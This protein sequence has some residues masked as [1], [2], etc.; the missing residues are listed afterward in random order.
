MQINLQAFI[1]LKATVHST[2][3]KYPSSASLS[4]LQGKYTSIVNPLN[5]QP[6][7]HNI[8]EIRSWRRRA[9]ASNKSLKEDPEK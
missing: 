2:L 1:T 6:R 5:A 9:S 7:T 3:G 4:P 8:M